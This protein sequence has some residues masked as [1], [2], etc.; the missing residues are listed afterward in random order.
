MISELHQQPPVPEQ[1]VVSGLIE[2]ITFFNE[3]TG[4][5]VLKVKAEGHRDLVTVVGSLAS[6]NAGEW[7]TA[8]GR[9]LQDREFGLQLRADLLRCVAPTTPEGI[10]RYLGSGMVKGIG[11]VYA[12]KLVDKFGE[13]I[14]DIIENYSSRLEEI[15]GIGT[16]RRKKIKDAWVEQKVIREIMVFLHSYGVSTSRAVRIYKTYGESAIDAVRANPYSLARDIR[17]IGF[18]TA[19]QIAQ[20]LGV[21]PDSLPRAC[22]ALSHILLEA[23]SGGHCAL[24]AQHLQEDACRLLSVDKTIVIEALAQSLISGAVLSE[25]IAGEELIFLPHLRRAEEGIAAKIKELCA[26]SAEPLVFDVE[27]AIA[28]SAREGGKE[29]GPPSRRQ[30]DKHSATVS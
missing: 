30:C 28:W 2:R 19:D 10:E 14:F 23:T 27:K 26:S 3:E 29:L 15:E 16:A 6:V 18:K 20:R 5:A 25:T 4:F 17:G 12:K 13:H 24:P 7:L 9:W 21:A 11:P 8:Q 1:N 22:A